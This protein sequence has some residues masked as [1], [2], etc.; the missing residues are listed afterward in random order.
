MYTAI[1]ISGTVSAA[2]DRDRRHNCADK[3][4]LDRQTD[5]EQEKNVDF[6]HYSSRKTLQV[7]CEWRKTLQNR[8]L[9]STHSTSRMLNQTENTS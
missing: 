6:K 7:P 9:K 4:R 1:S 5:E 3:E 8:A 2:A